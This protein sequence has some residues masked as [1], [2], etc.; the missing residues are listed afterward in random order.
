[1]PCSKPVASPCHALPYTMSFMKNTLLVG[2]NNIHERARI[3]ARDPRLPAFLTYIAGICDVL[4]L[5]V[6]ADE[7]FFRA[8]M[9][10]GKALADILGQG[11]L[12]DLRDVLVRVKGLKDAVNAYAKTPQRYDPARIIALLSFGDDFRRKLGTQIT[13]VDVRVVANAVPADEMA[14]ALKGIIEW[15]CTQSDITFLVPFIH[16]HHNRASSQYWPPMTREGWEVL[17]MM[18][19]QYASCWELA[20]YK[21]TA[22]AKK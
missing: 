8:R 9:Q 19:K 20:P 5:H 3:D 22:F 2:L 7:R 6:K 17:P 18:A 11:C 21:S 13:S 10:K 4:A 12:P 15:M 16:A 14:A 1:M